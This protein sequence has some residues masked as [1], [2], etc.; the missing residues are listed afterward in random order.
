MDILVL[1]C[2][3]VYLLI[4]GSSEHL[5]FNIWKVLQVHREQKLKNNNK[6]LQIVILVALL[7]SWMP[8]TYLEWRW[9]HNEQG[10]LS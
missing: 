4:L 8:L 6:I 3:S 10:V 7:M 1:W 9:N 2:M 5:W